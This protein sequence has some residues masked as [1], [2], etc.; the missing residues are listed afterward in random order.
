MKKTVIYD[1]RNDGSYE[2]LSTSGRGLW[3]DRVKG[4]RI[5]KIVARLWSEEEYDEPGHGELK[6]YYDPRDWKVNRNGLIYTDPLFL[7]GLYNLLRRLGFRASPN[8]VWYSE[9]GCQGNHYVHLR[10]GPA[11]YRS[12]KRNGYEMEKA[13]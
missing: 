1:T 10:T 8:S 4:I 9:Q 5:N 11:F 6:V 3:G 7:R 2:L 12:M 13:Q